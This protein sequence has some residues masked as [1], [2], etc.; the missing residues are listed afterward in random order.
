MCNL[1]LSTFPKE[2]KKSKVIELKEIVF[3]C[4]Y[5]RDAEILYYSD[6]DDLIIIHKAGFKEDLK[7]IKI[8]VIK[9]LGFKQKDKNFSF[10][11]MNKLS[12]RNI[13][14]GYD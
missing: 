12:K 4:H 10:V 2:K 14:G 9:E 13:G 11:K 1:T 3:S 8:E 6:I 7:I 5:D